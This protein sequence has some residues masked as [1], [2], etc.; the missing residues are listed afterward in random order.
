MSFDP[1][2]KASLVAALTADP[3]LPAAGAT[4]PPPDGTTPP[5]DEG[6]DT[7]D[8]GST[9]TKMCCDVYFHALGSQFGYADGTLVDIV[10]AAQLDD[11]G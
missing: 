4:G 11:Q 6:F 9:I 7:G 5:P 1:D 10:T 3:P 2:D 8:D